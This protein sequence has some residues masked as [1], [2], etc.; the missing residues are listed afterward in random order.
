MDNK[1]K[2][3][4]N[5]ILKETVLIILTAVPL[6][7]LGWIYTAL[8]DQ[9]PLHFD[10]NGNVNRYGSK[11]ELW[12]VPLLVNVLTYV[13]LRF[14]PSIDPK[15]QI[16]KMGSKWY[17]FKLAILLMMTVISF[18]IIFET[19]TFMTTSS[20]DMDTSWI[21]LATGILFVVVGNFL[22]AVKPNYFVGIRTP[23]TLESD[24]VWRKTHRLGGWL[25]VTIGIIVATAAIFL[26]STI[27][28]YVLIG[29]TL[30][31]VLITAIYSY[32][33][34]KKIPS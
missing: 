8:P 13:L 12:V 33:Q 6:L 10:L 22:P 16:R 2:I 27:A 32:L 20:R 30:G 9:V 21:F 18:W 34:F 25:F 4:K 3:M 14:A 28:F 5:S 15:D 23:W 1:T 11:M 19:S 26:E 17:Y 24:L 31:L 7:Y 29:T